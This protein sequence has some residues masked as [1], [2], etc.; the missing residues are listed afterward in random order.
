MQDH[1]QHGDH[2]AGHHEHPRRGQA[3]A[4]GVPQRGDHH[5]ERQ[6]DRLDD[7]VELQRRGGLAGQAQPR[8]WNCS[9]DASVAATSPDRARATST[10]SV[11]ALIRMAPSAAAKPSTVYQSGRISEARKPSPMSRA[12]SAK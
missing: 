2:D 7:P 1:L 11:S 6:L 12:A 4:D 10:R 3:T 8:D 5:E 9:A